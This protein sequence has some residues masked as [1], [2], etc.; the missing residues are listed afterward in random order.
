M[1]QVVE[2]RVDVGGRRLPPVG[3]LE[4]VGGAR[5]NTCGRDSTVLAARRR[6]GGLRRAMYAAGARAWVS[7]EVRE[8]DRLATCDVVHK[9]RHVREV[10]RNLALKCA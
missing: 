5:L 9:A 3:S 4:A 6:R 7:V 2:E 8:R 1:L 10:C